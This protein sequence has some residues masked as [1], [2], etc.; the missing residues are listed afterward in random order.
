MDELKIVQ[1]IITTQ[2]ELCFKV[3]SWACGLVTALTIGLFHSSINLSIPVYVLC[4]LITTVG[5][6]TV[7]RYHWRTYLSAVVR[8]RQIENEIN[9]NTYQ[10]I[11]I[12]NVLKANKSIVWFGG[13]KL[14]L[15]YIILSLVVIIASAY[16]YFQQVN[17]LMEFKFLSEFKELYLPII[18][19]LFLGYIAYQQMSTN[20]K[21]L[22]LELYH[23]R[24]EV[25]SI[26][27]KFH[28]ELMDEAGLAKGTHREFIEAKQSSKF[29][30]HPE[31]GIYS[32]LEEIN[33]KSFIVKAFK[34]STEV[35][36]IKSCEDSQEAMNSIINE[37][38]ALDGKMSKYLNF[39]R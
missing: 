23:K 6:F 8:S 17:L 11:K 20:R 12:N 21:K 9:S 37:V 5:F 4:G 15:P 26:T 19:A 16:N 14:Y 3:F 30:F 25:Y 35:N 13:Y 2:E 10:G 33:K 28:Q 24:F 27:L 1:D 34:L 39:Y 7:A 22:R 29:L 38:D 36:N 18:M 31:D 32:S